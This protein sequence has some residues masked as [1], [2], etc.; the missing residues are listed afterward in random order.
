MNIKDYLSRALEINKNRYNG[1]TYTDKKGDLTLFFKF[2]KEFKYLELGID[3]FRK[4]H[5]LDYKKYLIIKGY[6]GKTINCR[7]STISTFFN[8]AVDGEI[9]DKNYFDG[10]KRVKEVQTGINR[11]FSDAEIDLIKGK[12]KYDYP[13]LWLACMLMFYGFL[14]PNEIRQL[15]VK[16]IDFYSKM[17]YVGSIV[18]KNKKSN[19]VDIPGPLIKLLKD[20]LKSNCESENYLITSR[21]VPGLS[22]MGRNTL[23]DKYENIVKSLNLDIDC[24]FYSWKHTGVVKAYRSGIDVKALQRQGRWHSL[25]QVDKYLKSLGLI[26]NKE[27]TSKMN[28]VEI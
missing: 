18:S 6:A 7:I 28:F 3:E 20:Y 4:V 5:A 15:K 25:E 14:R 22:M 2:L 13:D 12:L 11:A 24:T 8:E 10:I 1:R 23:R 16:N 9:I 26:E 17:V 19:Q 21:G 27:F